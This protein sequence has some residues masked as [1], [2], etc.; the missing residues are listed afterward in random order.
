MTV[1]GIK[2]K[3]NKAVPEPIYFLAGHG[4]NKK[5]SIDLSKK[6]ADRLG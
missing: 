5:K 1:F 3:K 6:N 4:R 2:V